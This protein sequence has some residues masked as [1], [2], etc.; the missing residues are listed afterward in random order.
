MGHGILV[1]AARVRKSSFI[2]GANNCVTR[3]DAKKEP[4]GGQ[5][6]CICQLKTYEKP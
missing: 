4:I 6:K 3:C 1:T 5:Y 2:I